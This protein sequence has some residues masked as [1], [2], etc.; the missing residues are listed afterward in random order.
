MSKGGQITIHGAPSRG[1]AIP[2]IKLLRKHSSAFLGLKEA[3]DILDQ[4]RMDHKPTLFVLDVDE[5]CTEFKAIGAHVAPSGSTPGELVQR[6][7]E[8][9]KERAYLRSQLA[10]WIRGQGLEIDLRHMSDSKLL[11]IAKLIRIK[12]A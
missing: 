3:K 2:F 7:K 11:G 4:S 6:L 9:G 5:A 1:Q 10:A 8:L 12:Q